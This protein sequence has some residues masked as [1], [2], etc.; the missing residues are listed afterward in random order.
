[1]PWSIPCRKRIPEWN[2]LQKK[3][4]EKLVIAGI[5]SDTEEEVAQMPEPKP[6]FFSAIDTKA[7]L[8]TSL[9]VPSIPYVV[10]LDAKGAVRSQ[11]HPAVLD[12][13]KIEMITGLNKEE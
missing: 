5:T 1:A 12:E 7:V 13:K 10:A 11:G 8:G 2:A 4:G 6:E 3:F 9:N